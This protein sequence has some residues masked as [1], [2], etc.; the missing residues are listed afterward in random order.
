M[1]RMV[2]SFPEEVLEHVFS[3]IQVDTDRNAISLVCKSWYEIERWCRRKVFVGNCYAVSPMI[4]IKRFPEVRSIALKGKPHFADFNLVPEGWGG[5]VCTWIAAMSRAFPWLEEIRLKRMVISD[6]S[7][8]LIAKS[9]KNFKVLVLTSCEGFTTDGLAAIAANCRNLREL[10]L[11]ESEVEDLSGH[12]LSHFPDS[13]TSL[14]SLNI[15]CLSNEVSLS[16]LERLLGRCPNMKTLRLNRAVPLDRL[17]NLLRQCP[18]LVELG[19]G[20]YSAEMRPDVFSNLAAAFSGCK[21]LKSLSGFWDVLP[22]YLPAVY[23]VCSGL[24]SLN[25]SYATVQS[26]DLV[27]LISQC[28]SL[29]RLWVL[30]FIE[31]AGLDVLAASCKDLR[32]LRV[33]PSDPFGFEPN[34]ALT[35]RG[36]VSVSEGCPKLQS[37]LY[38]CRQ[39]E[40]VFDRMIF[41]AHT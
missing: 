32:E 24:T 3:F 38:F 2:C 41:I 30:D 10:D 23:P 9:F 7:L 35:E 29:Q 5:Y 33:F 22:S 4:V 15:S 17:P 11:Q 28:P 26:S 27:K 37:V 8:E 21:Q 20:V 34:V 1:K 31:D 14:V 12:W 40:M 36:L 39:S 13:Y 19:T 25:L 6:E 16:A 18:Q